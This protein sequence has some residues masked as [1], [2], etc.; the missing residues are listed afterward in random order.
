MRRIELLPGSPCDSC[1]QSVET[2]CKKPVYLEPIMGR[3]LHRDSKRCPR[4]ISVPACSYL[5]LAGISMSQPSG[6]LVQVTDEQNGW[7][8]SPPLP[9]QICYEQNKCC[10]K[11]SLFEG[12]YNIAFQHKGCSSNK[13]TKREWEPEMAELECCQLCL[14][15]GR[16]KWYDDSQGDI[17]LHRCPTLG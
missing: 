11:A 17:A 10:F 6:D 1:L 12:A 5:S 2:A 7:K 14:A 3:I 4:S 8:L 9:T 15:L 16:S 13:E